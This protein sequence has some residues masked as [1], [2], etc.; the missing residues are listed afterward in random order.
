MVKPWGGNMRFSF[1]TALII[2]LFPLRCLSQEP[3]S[4]VTGFWNGFLNQ[5]NVVE[6]ASI[7]DESGS[8]LLT[9][10]GNSGETVGTIPFSLAPLGTAHIVLNILPITNSYGTFLIEQVS[11]SESLPRCHTAFYRLA[12][13]GATKS[14]EY[15]FSLPELNPITRTS[16]GVYNSINPSGGTNPVFN[17]L[18]VVNPGDQPFNATV[19]IYQQDGSLDSALSFEIVDLLPAERRDFPLGHNVGQIVGLYEIIP[20]ESTSEYGAFLN[21]YSADA[22]GTFQFAFSLLALPGS[23]DPGPIPASTMDPATNWGEIANPRATPLDVAIE[24][25]NPNGVLLFEEERTIP[26]HAQYHLYLNSILGERAIGSF[27]VRCANEGNSEEKLLA[28]SL[29]Y[30]RREPTSTNVEWAYGT[31]ARGVAAAR[32]TD[33]LSFVNTFLQA[34]NW[35]KVLAEDEISFPFE[36]VQLNTSGSRLTAEQG[37]VPSYGNVDLGLHEAVGPDFVG[38]AVTQI[39]TSGASYVS[40]LLRVFPDDRGGIGY[41]MNIPNVVVPALVLPSEEEQQPT[42]NTPVLELEELISGL[43]A[44]VYVGHAGDDTGRLFIVELP[45]KIKIFVSGSLL[46]TPF[47]DIES[48]VSTGGERGLFSFAFHPDFSENRRLY[49]HYTDNS[50]DSVIAQYSVSATNSNFVD[51]QTER[52]LLT[53]PQPFDNHNGGQINFGPDGYLYIGMGDGGSGGDPFNHGQ[54]LATL[55]GSLLR[56][57][58]DGGTPY[59]VPADNPFVNTAGAEPEIWAYGLRNPWRFSFDRLDGRLFLADVGQNEIEEVDLI[60]RGGNYGW[61]IMEGSE[62]YSPSQNC[63]QTGLILPI[64]EYTHDE[65]TSVTGGYLYRG[66][67]IRD[68]YGKYIFGDY[69]SG[70]VWVLTEQSNGSWN[71]TEVLQSGLFISSFG[72]DEEGELYLVAITGAVYRI[73][74]GSM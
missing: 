50:G 48:R 69:G 51:P 3:D 2:F 11:G 65:G 19:N 44:P 66:E 18:S 57:D 74:E 32:N 63:N 56:I 42:P 37:S 34:A 13:A 61:K 54:D 6:C 43:S 67:S 58:V 45:G 55:L 53:I 27:H 21:R 25:R 60:E 73:L 29:F 24:V 1:S 16:T 36:M 39:D 14:V 23:C 4:A 72:E 26:G 47:L 38:S 8:Y 12:Q 68:L 10:R 40:E 52:I 41:I 30:G 49:V 33:A 71:R 22:S 64:A 17:W 31:Q 35:N 15:A 20:N 9:L 28:Q 70:R 5:M 62:C 46:E 7:S 59:A